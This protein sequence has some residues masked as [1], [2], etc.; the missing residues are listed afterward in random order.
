MIDPKA[1]AEFNQPDGTKAVTCCVCRFVFKFPQAHTCDSNR[2][3]YHQWLSNP[4]EGA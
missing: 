2:E 1:W 3:Q 4:I